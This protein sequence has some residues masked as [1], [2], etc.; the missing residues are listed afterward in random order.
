[1]FEDL[2]DAILKNISFKVKTAVVI[3]GQILG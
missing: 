2:L 3:F 1:M